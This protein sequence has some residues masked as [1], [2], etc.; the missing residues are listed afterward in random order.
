MEILI[1]SDPEVLEHLYTRFPYLSGQPLL[2]RGAFA[3]QGINLGVLEHHD[4][5]AFLVAELDA[6]R[7]YLA[8]FPFLTLEE[9]AAL[10]CYRQGWPVEPWPQP[11]V[12]I[13]WAGHRGDSVLMDVRQVDVLLKPVGTVQLWWGDEIG[14][15]WEAVFD[16]LPSRNQE[17]LLH[18]LW[19][20]CEDSLRSKSVRFI[21]TYG[22]DPVVEDAVYGSFLWERGYRRDPAR[23]HLPAGEVAVVKDL[24]KTSNNR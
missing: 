2:L 6:C 22:R 12:D 14:V 9:N 17:P 21:H 20:A 11:L 18:Q 3:E 19:A 10:S 4:F 5:L 23:A 13:L 24:G 15:I 1:K 16:P 8:D 7:P